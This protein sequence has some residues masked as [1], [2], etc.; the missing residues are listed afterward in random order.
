MPEPSPHPR[1]QD[2]T[3]IPNPRRLLILTPSQ[4]SHTTIPPFLHSLTGTPVVDPP[5]STIDQ[6]PDTDSKGDTTTTTTTTTTFAGYTTHPPLKLENRYYK[7]EVPIWVDEIPLDNSPGDVNANVDIDTQHERSGLNPE[8]KEGQGEGDL[9]T[10]KTWQKEFSGPEAKVVRDAIG[11]VVISPSTEQDMEERPEW[12]GLKTFLEAVGFV[13]G[14]MDEERGGLGDVLGLVVLV[15][16]GRESGVGAR[17]I[18]GDPDEVNDL[19]EEEVFSV[20]WWEDKLFDL[21]LVGFEVVNWDPREVGLSEER[22]RFGEYQGMRRVREILE[23]HDWASTPSGESGGVDD[24]EDELEGHLLEDG[25]DLEV[26]ELERE[27][28][29]LRFAIE[30]GGDDLGGIDGDDEI[31]VESME[32]LMLRMK[33]IKGSTCYAL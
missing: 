14:V 26:N 13:K 2:P 7:A 12:K 9:L 16:R 33:A 27:M 21:G 30:N 23:T 10:P 17:T 19:G 3:I 5:T 28:V 18:S 4:H 25:F 31:K 8:D 32:A 20:P 6:K 1:K 11:G 24:V 29:G 22:D 15:G